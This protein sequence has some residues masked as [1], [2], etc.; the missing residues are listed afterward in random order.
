MTDEKPKSKQEQMRIVVKNTLENKLFQ[1]IVGSN[2]VKN[3]PMLYGTYG[4]NG[5]NTT[6]DTSMKSDDV[7]KIRAQLYD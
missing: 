7:N 3:D 2:T 4:L 5:G 1:D 6:Y